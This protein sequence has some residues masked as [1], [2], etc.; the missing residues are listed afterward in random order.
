MRRLICA[1]VVRNKPDDR[2]SHIKAHGIVIN[3]SLQEFCETDSNPGQRGQ[4]EFAI[5]SYE[6]NFMKQE[7]QQTS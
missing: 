2:F 7:M 5:G 1:F 6:A 3:F 4:L